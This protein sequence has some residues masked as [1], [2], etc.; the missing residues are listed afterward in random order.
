M[1]DDRTVWDGAYNRRG[2]L[3]GGTI[4]PVPDLPHGARVLEL[5][6][7]NGRNTGEFVR[8]GCDVVAL[9]FSRAAVRS[10]RALLPAN[11]PGHA[12][13]ADARFLP[14]KS[15]TCNAVIARH[16]VGHMTLAGR[17]EVARETCRVLKEN[18]TLHFFAFSRMDFRYGQGEMVEEDTFLRGNG[19]STHYFSG[20]EVRDLFAPLAC[21]SLANPQWSLRIRG[22][23][24]LRAEI[25][26]VFSRDAP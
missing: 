19:I 15:G 2:Q 18:G 23:E 8:K 1:T 4:Q 16:V 13:V 25:H 17:R 21:R 14:L 12:L 7:G 24:Y 22:R 3:Y 10:A 6:C 9:D 5:G 26:A 11:G 20:D